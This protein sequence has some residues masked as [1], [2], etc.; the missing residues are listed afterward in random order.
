MKTSDSIR[1]TPE[2][3]SSLTVCTYNVHNWT[4]A[5]GRHDPGRILRIMAAM[6]AD[7]IAAQ[8]VSL[9][10]EPR[11]FGERHIEAATGM[12]TITGPT[13]VKR[14]NHYGNL[15]LSS[16]QPT[17]VRRL[18]LSVAAREPR[19]ALDVTWIIDGV[20]VRA[21]AA[22]LGLQGGERRNQVEALLHAAEHEREGIVILLGDFNV[23]F[24]RSR[25][26]RRI[27]DAFG[28]SPALRTYPSFCPLLRLDRVWVKPHSALRSIEVI[29]TSE[30]AAASDH[31]PVR[32]RIALTRS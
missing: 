3:R 31:L 24:P 11:G 28:P 29:R 16:L 1:S 22:H 21:I 25:L 18:D 27:E 2:R 15:I 26:L 30:A 7:I 32:A 12:K 17:E 23:W 4:G 8:E 5:D 19:G 13:L 14:R 20:K 9:S 10:A 6:N